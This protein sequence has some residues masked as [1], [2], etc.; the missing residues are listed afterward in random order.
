[1]LRFSARRFFMLSR[2]IEQAKAVLKVVEGMED[3]ADRA[4]TEEEGAEFRNLADMIVRL[5]EAMSLPASRALWEKARDDIPRTTKEWS[6]LTTAVEAE[7]TDKYFLFVPPDRSRFYNVELSAPVRAAFPQASQELIYAGNA[8]ACGLFTACVS[9]SMR[10]AEAGVRALAF[11]LNVMFSID[12]ALVDWASLLDQI[13]S[14]VRDM[15]QLP[16]GA[17]KDEDLQ[18]Y[19]EAASQFRWFKDGWRVRVAHSRASYDENQ[20]V[21][22]LEHTTDFF[23][24]ISTRLKE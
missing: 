11:D 2:A 9:H 20:A 12:L 10:A 15:K 5:T 18:F 6:L 13:D 3:M 1:M 21:R 7:L 16:R 8:Y 14:K 17:K 19:S 24:T 23:A 22:V 4:L